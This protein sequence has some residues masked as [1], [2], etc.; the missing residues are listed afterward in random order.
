MEGPAFEVVLV[1]YRSAPLVRRLVRAWGP[2]VGVVVVDNASG[3]DGL[4][5]LAAECPWVSYLDGGGV[6]FARAANRGA[7]QARS[8]YVVF[9]NPDSDPS[10]ADL[11]A[12]VAGVAADPTALSHAATVTDADGRPEVGV[13]GWEPSIARAVVFGFG[14]HKVLRRAGIYAHPGPGERL[15]VGWTTGA[16]MAV[17]RSDF[18]RLGGF[19]ES[20]YVYCEDLSLGRRARRAG[21]RQVL[22][23]DVA[24][25]HGAGGSG[26]PSAEM[27]RMRGAA[28]ANYMERYHPAQAR[29]V[30]AA[31]WA[32]H[33]L[34][35]KQRLL[36]GDTAAAAGFSA[37]GHGVRTR[38]AF[39]GG[40]EVAL[41][42][43]EETAVAAPGS[44]R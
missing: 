33:A 17:R 15:S 3:A 12:L 42:R 39:V 20:F 13:G 28:I 26:A 40:R 44:R 22:R 29:A 10:V 31:L 16:C 4:E 35:A 6:G 37:Y 18:L 24:V 8:P 38:R 5:A 23:A 36:H 2:E 1:A 41:A 30:R 14:L 32:G 19:D 27:L 25:R 7:Q 34:R 9:V 43:I 21:L 11:R